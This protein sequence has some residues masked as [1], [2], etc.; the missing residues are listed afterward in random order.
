MKSIGCNSIKFL[1][2]SDEAFQRGGSQWVMY[3]P[4]ECAAI[5]EAAREADI[6]LACLA[7][8]AEAVKLS[9]RSGFRSICHCTYAD[10]EAFDL[11]ESR[12]DETFVARAPPSIDSGLWIKLMPRVSYRSSFSTTG[13]IRPEERKGAS[14]R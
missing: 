10:E 13:P 2:S 11:F 5:S 14:A 4:E 1:L 7:Q 6:W 9:V 3:S 12:K 8:G